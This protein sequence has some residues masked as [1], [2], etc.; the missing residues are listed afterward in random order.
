MYTEFL[1]KGSHHTNTLVFNLDQL[2]FSDQKEKRKQGQNTH[3]FVLF[4]NPRCQMQIGVLSR[5][6]GILNPKTVQE[7][8]RQSTCLDN[9][10]GYLIIDTR[11][12][13]ADEVRLISR[14]FPEEYPPLCYIES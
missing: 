5:Q 10:Y 8:Y 6:L 11:A 1:T 13:T 12:D 2:L 9:K 7:A 14:I 3:V 4:R